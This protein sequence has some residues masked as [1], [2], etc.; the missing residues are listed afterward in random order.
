MS[1]LICEVSLRWDSHTF[2]VQFVL[3]DP[4]NNTPLLTESVPVFCMVE[5]RPISK[6]FKTMIAEGYSSF[7]LKF[8][9]SVDDKYKH[10]LIELVNNTKS[11]HVVYVPIKCNYI[12]CIIDEIWC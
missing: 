12:K 4:H 5:K 9:S 11:T 6:I 3:R 1:N 8:D 2:D 7:E 10:Y